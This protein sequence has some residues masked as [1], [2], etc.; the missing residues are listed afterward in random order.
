MVGEI[1]IYVHNPRFVLKRDEG[2]KERKKR[3]WWVEDYV[4]RFVVLYVSRV[5]HITDTMLVV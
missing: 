3:R 4:D 2:G 1:F 5:D